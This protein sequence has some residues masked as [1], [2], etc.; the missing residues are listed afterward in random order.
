LNTSNI[1]ARELIVVLV[2]CSVDDMVMTYPDS[3]APIIAPMNHLAITFDDIA[4]AHARLLDVAHRTPVLRSSSA[5]ALAGAQLF[6]KCENLQRGGAFKFRGAYN[7][8]AQFSAEQRRCGV[9]AFSSGNH[10][11]AIA[12]AA[13]LLEMPAVI[14]MPADAPRG[15]VDATRAYGAEIV[16]YDRFAEDREALSKAL[17]QQRGLTLI[18]PFDHPHVIA[19]Q[20]TVAKELLEEVADLDFLLTPV[21][22]GGLLSGCAVAAH[23]MAKHCVVVGVEPQA[24]NDV[25]QSLRA[26]QLVKIAVPHTIADG[27][28]TPSAGVLTFPIIQQQVSDIVTV[29]DAELI[30][31]MR[32]FFTR[33][34]IVVEPTGCLAAAAVFF[35][36]IPIAGKRVGIVLSGGNVDAEQ[37]ASFIKPA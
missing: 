7:A 26:G 3:A 1:R 37:F 18:P 24:G 36:K 29:S 32:F 28:Q 20:G 23:A 6:F 2:N 33:M 16:S 4:A 15:K 27:A 9:L 8:L 10:A 34:K 21:G 31:A 22:G 5:D 19:G 12:L 17:A 11:Q 14:V 35:G 30:E 13:R 25:Q